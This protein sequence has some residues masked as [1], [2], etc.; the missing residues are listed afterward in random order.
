MLAWLKNAVIIDTSQ[1]GNN[2]NKIKEF[3]DLAL[4]IACIALPFVL[5]FAFVMKP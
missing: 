4:C 5:Y 2:M 3:F 1:Q